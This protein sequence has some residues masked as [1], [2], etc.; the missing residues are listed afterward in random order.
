MD[1]PGWN[2]ANFTMLHI[3]QAHVP[4]DVLSLRRAPAFFVLISGV[5]NLAIYFG[6]PSSCF[7]LLVP[8]PCPEGGS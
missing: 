5:H 4:G 7:P 8:Q 6:L 3:L 1:K 2:F